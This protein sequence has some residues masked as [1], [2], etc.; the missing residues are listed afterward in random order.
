MFSKDYEVLEIIE[1]P[2]EKLFSRYSTTIIR[3]KWK[4]GDEQNIYMS[5]Y[6]YRAWKIE[7]EIIE[8]YNV[9]IDLLEDYYHNANSQGYAEAMDDNYEQP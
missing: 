8:K 9:P 6:N 1:P 3:V 5:K 7:K 2:K 4:N